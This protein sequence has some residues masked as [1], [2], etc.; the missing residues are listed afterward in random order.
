MSINQEKYIPNNAKRAPIARLAIAAHQDDVEIMAYS[1]IAD[2]FNNASEG[3][4][5]VITSDG[6]GSAR[7]S[8]YQNY[9]D[10]Q[11][12][13]IRA[14]EQKQAAQIGQYQLLHLL[15]YPSSQIQDPQDSKIINDYLNI[16]NDTKPRIIYTHN[17][18][19]KHPTHQ[20]VAIKTIQAIRLMDKSTRPS[21]VLGVEV[22]RGLDWLNND[23]KVLLD[24][25][26]HPDLEQQLLKVFDSQISGGKRYD[27]AVIGRR[28]A[29]AVFLESH[30]IDQ[31]QKLNI[32]MDLTPL[33]LDDNLDICDYVLSF[34][35]DFKKSV[36]D[37]IKK[38]LGK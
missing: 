29:N 19:D 38:I 8:V 17:L 4:C 13:T 20:A 26:Q 22:W 7:S 14:N 37:S 35:N 16:L 21:K 24:C 36:K 27:L 32:A 31:Y 6:A 28:R 10:Q 9:T 33:I 34:I 12:S 11:I 15:N 1:A 25:S 2:C 18:A 23:Q 5:A 3:F 30:N